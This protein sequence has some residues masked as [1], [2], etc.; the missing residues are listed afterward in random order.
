MSWST[1]P[2][3]SRPITALGTAL[4]SG[5]LLL[6]GC[7]SNAGY[8]SLARRPA[9]LAVPARQPAGAAPASSPGATGPSGRLLALVTEARAAHER[10]TGKRVASESAIAGAAGELPGS[11]DWARATELLAD[12][13][14]AHTATTSPLAELDRIDIDDRLAHAGDDPDGRAQRPEAAAIRAAVAEVGILVDDESA[15]LGTLAGRLRN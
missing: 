10:F 11:D 4:L 2:R 1:L 3:L 6:G 9:E 7:G 8:P 12:L 15:A 13:E 5:A 14:S